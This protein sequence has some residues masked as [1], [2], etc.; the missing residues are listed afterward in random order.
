M[1]LSLSLELEGSCSSAP[2]AMLEGI[3]KRVKK[4]MMIMMMLMMVIV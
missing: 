1:S 3:K 2:P 4:M